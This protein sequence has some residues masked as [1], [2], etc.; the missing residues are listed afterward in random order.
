MLKRVGTN[1][2]TLPLRHLGG[3]AIP[4]L[5]NNF[6]R[7]E[8]YNYTIGDGVTSKLAGLPNGHL[9]PSSWILPY[10]PGGISSSKEARIVFNTPNLNVNMVAIYKVLALLSLYL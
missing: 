3:G 8:R 10:R 4:G 2:S 7:T 1:L 5:R 6:T 9:T